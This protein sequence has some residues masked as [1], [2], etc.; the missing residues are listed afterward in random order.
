VFT[1]YLSACAHDP[2]F[3]QTA[4]A[5]NATS[6]V[7]AASKKAVKKD[8][9]N[10]SYDSQTKETNFQNNPYVVKGRVYRPKVD[11]DYEEEGVASWYSSWFHGRKTSS[12]SR[13]D[14]NKYTAAH[15]TLPI[16]SVVKVTNLENNKSVVVIVN[17]RGP[18]HRS[19]KRALIDLSKKAA[20]DLDIIQQGIAKVKIELLPIFNRTF[21]FLVTMDC[22]KYCAGCE[23]DVKY[24]KRILYCW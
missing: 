6:G 17:D 3:T 22:S 24:Q 16:P 18:F 15:K 9:V 23:C 10:Y 5:V 13:Y 20:K 2:A 14:E 21:K 19:N 1:L 11:I 8:L 12:G 7:S 4:S